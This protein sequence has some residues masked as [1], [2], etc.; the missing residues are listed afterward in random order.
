MPDRKEDQNKGDRESGGKKPEADRVTNRKAVS[1]PAAGKVVKR[2]APRKAGTV[3]PF[4][5]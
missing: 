3:N 5:Y 2:A 1:K 4:G